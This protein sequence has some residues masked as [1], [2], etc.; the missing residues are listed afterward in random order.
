[1]H[2]ARAQHKVSCYWLFS[3][4]CQIATLHWNYFMVQCF[5]FV[6]VCVC[7]CISFGFGI[8]D[9]KILTRCTFSAESELLETIII[10][11][12][13]FCALNK[14]YFALFAPFIGKTVDYHNRV[15]GSF[16]FRCFAFLFSFCCLHSVCV[17]FTLHWI[18]CYTKICIFVN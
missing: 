8:P 9:I 12:L 10:I 5:F 3:A 14:E 7:S 11:A 2:D 17:F 16:S 18:K 15:R 13:L 1:M 6:C 4:I